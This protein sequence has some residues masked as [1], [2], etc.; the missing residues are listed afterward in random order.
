[1]NSWTRPPVVRDHTSTTK[2]MQRPRRAHEAVGV[3]QGCSSRSRQCRFD[4]YG[5]S[6]MESELSELVGRSCLRLNV[7]WWFGEKGLSERHP[8]RHFQ[9]NNVFG[10]CSKQIIDIAGQPERSRI[11]IRV[12]PLRPDDE[13]CRAGTILPAQYHVRS[14]ILHVERRIVEL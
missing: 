5:P 14:K 12:T 2:E 3:E 9:Q 7:G 13:E 11:G 8:S 1:M 10:N 4:A 6:E